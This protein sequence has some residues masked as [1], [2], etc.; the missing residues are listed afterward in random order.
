MDSLVENNRK[1][2]NLGKFSQSRPKVHQVLEDFDQFLAKN[3]KLPKR[4]LRQANTGEFFDFY[5]IYLFTF[6]VKGIS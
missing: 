5:I 1:F 3:R 4:T 2:Q 6:S